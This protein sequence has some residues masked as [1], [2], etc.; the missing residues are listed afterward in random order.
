M[1]APVQEGPS[2]HSKAAP[3][4]QG[5]SPKPGRHSTAG[6]L[7]QRVT[8]TAA[9]QAGPG[10]HS[11]AGGRGP[12]ASLLAGLGQETIPEGA[13]PIPEGASPSSSQ[14]TR[15]ELVEQPGLQHGSTAVELERASCA[16]GGWGGQGGVAPVEPGSSATEFS[17]E[18]GRL[19]AEQQAGEQADG[20]AQEERDPAAGSHEDSILQVNKLPALPSHAGGS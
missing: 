9:I 2:R 14:D 8:G 13:S 6:P 7:Q 12:K 11:S 3:L 16:D 18:A 17:A 19:L 20:Q 15:D 1:I 4:Q 5:A 10:R